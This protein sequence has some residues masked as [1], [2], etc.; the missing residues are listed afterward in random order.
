MLYNNY[1]T[2]IRNTYPEK[3]VIKVCIDGGFSCPNRDGSV[4]TGGCIF[5]GE[6]GAGEHIARRTP[7]RQIEHF[8]EK[9]P[10]AELFLAY[11]QNFTNTYAPTSVLKERYDSALCDPD[12]VGLI[13]GTRPDCITEENADLIAS[14][15]KTHNVWVELGLQSSSDA[16]GELINRG[17]RTERFIEAA[18]LLKSRGV[19]VV[20]HRIIGLPGEDRDEVMATVELINSLKIWGVKMHSLYVMKGTALEEMYKRGEYTPP[21]RLHYATLTAEALARLDPDMIV[22]R[23]TGDCQ[24]ELLVA[25]E[26]NRDKDGMIDAVRRQMRQNGW[27]QGSLY[28]IK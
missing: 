2:Y 6:R 16:T 15:T 14:Y 25:P 18:R 13:I 1:S 23:I 4:S 24:A 3:K 17:Y 8:K 12:V 26:W 7:A 21:T 22:H 27:R 11:F 28:S 19:K 20:A 9:C 10:R 5:C